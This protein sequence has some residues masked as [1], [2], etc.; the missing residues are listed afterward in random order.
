MHRLLFLL[1]ACG[2]APCAAQ[3]NAIP[4]ERH[5]LVYG[6]ATARAT[7]DRFQVTV[8]VRHTDPSADAARERVS[9]LFDQ[10]LESYRK[11][12]V[13]QDTLD[14]STLEIA[15]EERWDDQTRRQVFEGIRVSRTLSGTF[16]DPE[17]LSRF[18]ALIETSETVQVA[19]V[20]TQISTEQ[21][22]R[23]ALRRE[24][25]RS[26][27][28]R[29]AGLASAYG[30]TLGPLY[31]ASTVAPQF[32]YGVHEG[33]WYFDW[34]RQG[35]RY[36]LDRIEVTGSRIDIK[37]AQLERFVAGQVEMEERLYAVFLLGE[38]TPGDADQD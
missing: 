20:R 6:T 24:A 4:A 9:T 1:L 8:T 3:V 12:G 26:S 31:S 15:P 33:D 37:G 17:R 22:L 7:P 28:E 2:A 21:Q 18:L 10:V 16:D 14:A 29:A 27:K 35:D 36:T 19:G 5:I 23:A 38:P 13:L 25:I 32:S 34:R 30:T 11:A